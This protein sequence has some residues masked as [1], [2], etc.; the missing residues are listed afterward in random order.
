M[1]V[2]RLVLGRSAVMVSNMIPLLNEAA[3]KGGAAYKSHFD[4]ST[5]GKAIRSAL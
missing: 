2:P 1:D 5:H 3:L 4:L